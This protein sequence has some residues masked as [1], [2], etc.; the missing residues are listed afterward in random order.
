MRSHRYEP[1]YTLAD[2]DMWEGDWELIDGYPYA[3]SPSTNSKHQRLAGKLNVQL[4]LSLSSLRD[5]CNSCEVLYGL[6]NK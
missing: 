6:E 2:Y 1:N 3:M 4:V 5:G